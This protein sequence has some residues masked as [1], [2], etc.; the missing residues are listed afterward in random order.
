MNAV[1]YTY[2]IVP[3]RMKK[4][5]DGLAMQSIILE[6]FMTGKINERKKTQEIEVTNE[7]YNTF[8]KEQAHSQVFWAGWKI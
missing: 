3:K 1:F 7:M 6:A 8:M 4:L 2:I 5:S